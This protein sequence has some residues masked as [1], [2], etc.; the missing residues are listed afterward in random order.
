MSI[1]HY[2][3]GEWKIVPGTTSPGTKPKIEIVDGY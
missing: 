3:N 2:I 1:K